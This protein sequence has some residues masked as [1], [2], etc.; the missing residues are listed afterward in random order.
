MKATI[1]SGNA[2]HY[3]VLLNEIISIITPQYGGTFIDCT[4]GQGGYSKKILDYPDTK[5]IAIDRDI[6]S[7]KK[8]ENI[9]EKFENRFLFKN[10][11]FS[12]LTNLKLKKEDIKGIIFD[13]GYSYTQIKDPKKGLSF[14]FSG[15]LNMK[16][17]INEF[18]AKEVINKLEEKEL[19]KIFKYF[20]EE[21]ESKK[22]ARNIVEDRKSKEITTEELVRII[23]STK[24]KKNH[25]THSATKVF[26][27][28]RIFVNKEISELIYGLI[29]AAKVLKK[30]GIIAV[31]TFH[32]LEDK[33]VK[34]FFKSLSENKS[35]S[36]YLPKEDEKINLFK[37]I[38]KKPIIPSQKE[39]NENPP[40]RSA[41]LRYVVK[42]EDFFNF[43]TDILDK[44]NY[45]LEIEN[46]SEKL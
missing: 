31:V 42:K 20:G 43:E 23:E 32:S 34:Y 44:F 16:L 39:I 18:S 17:G 5:V 8:A 9:R 24:K 25:K 21:K 10:I 41:K 11:K 37:L 38:N 30:D 28:L 19:L 35:V 33:I 4:F 1:I 7:I 14:D 29:N 27:A 6:E 3:P 2:K 22:I 13:L 12:Q 45:L 36:R 40:S 26:Q 15:E 46:Y